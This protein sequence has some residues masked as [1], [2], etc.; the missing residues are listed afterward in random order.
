MEV[1]KSKL[2]SKR[3]NPLVRFMP[4]AMYVG[5]YTHTFIDR[6]YPSGNK[7]RFYSCSRCYFLLYT[8]CNFQKRTR[9]HLCATLQFFMLNLQLTRQ[10]PPLRIT[11]VPWAF[12]T[13]FN[14]WS[15]VICCLAFHLFYAEFIILC[16]KLYKI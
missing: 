15:G 4:L 3:A 7:G 1:S 16:I 10:R 13:F 5:V 12:L 14:P 2:T 11:V 9:C 8:Q 6:S